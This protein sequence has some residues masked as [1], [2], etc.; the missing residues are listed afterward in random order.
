M[1]KYLFILSG[2][3]V[4]LSLQAQ[5]TFEAYAD[6]ERIF[7]DGYFEV[8]FTL[9]NGEPTDFEPPSFRDF[10]VVSGPSR[11]MSTTVINGQVSK[12]LSYNFTLQP[13]RTGRLTVGSAQVRVKGVDMRTRPLTIEVVERSDETGGG[14]DFY[15]EAT[16][17][18]TE[19]F[20]GQQVR[21]DY[22]LYTKVEIQN[23]NIIEEPDYVGFYA[24]D[25]RRPD[26]RLK[27]EII[28]GEQYF[29]RTLKSV[30]LYPQQ[31]GTLTI[32][33]TLLQL[34]VITGDSDSYSLF[35]G[36][37]IKRVPVRTDS[38]NL[39]VKALPR[40]APEG[41]SGAVGDFRLRT[42]INRNTLTTDDALSITMEVSGNGDLKRVQP[43]DPDLPAT[44]DLYDPET[45]EYDLGELNGYRQGQKVFTF[46]A[47]PRE[48]G[49]TE[50][51]P[52]FVYFDPD[53]A[54]YLTE[55]GDT[56]S[57]TIRQGSRSANAPPVTDQ[58]ADQSGEL[59]PLRLNTRLRSGEGS[60]WVQSSWYWAATGLPLFLFLGLLVYRRRLKATEMID[61]AERRRREARLMATR[62]LDQAKTY[63]SQGNSRSFYDEISKAMLGYVSDKLQIERSDLSKDNVQAK[64]KELEVDQSKI[65]QFMGILNTC[66]TA[67]FAG[68]DQAAKMQEV[69]DQSLDMLAVIEQQIQS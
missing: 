24:A 40:P 48:A 5:P 64:L 47:Q 54:A 59:T 20:V 29:T 26:T 35:F 17:S 53:S 50:I 6:A 45:E 36:N 49:V 22:R 3:L 10:V 42:S 69:Y 13:R 46:L 41:F 8:T 38:V 1:I 25:I 16:P 18:R 7:E 4:G 9:R 12:E 21:L 52:S 67:L 58:L 23:Y 14:R 55:V 56:L 39:T 65:E 44:F 32:P 27:R 34:G 68:M 33:S 62:R 37:N 63:K 15:V 43:P 61:P 11:S 31:A 51:T 30:A 2:L 66:E 28:N 19:V 60:F 57:L